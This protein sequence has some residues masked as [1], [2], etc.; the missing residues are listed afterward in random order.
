MREFAALI[1]VGLAEAA[2]WTIALKIFLFI[3]VRHGPACL[4]M[5]F[6]KTGRV[7]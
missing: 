3:A 7:T 4:I 5:I 1:L 6:T 2:E